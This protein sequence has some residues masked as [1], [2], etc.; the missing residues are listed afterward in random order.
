[1]PQ[2]LVCKAVVVRS[3]SLQL[4]KSPCSSQLE[5]ACVQ[6]RRPSAT[7]TREIIK[8]SIS[9]AYWNYEIKVEYLTVGCTIHHCVII[10]FGYFWVPESLLNQSF[11]CG[12]QSS[13]YFTAPLMQMALKHI[14]SFLNLIGNEWNASYNHN[15]MLFFSS[16]KLN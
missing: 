16:I 12:I 13:V 8:M 15:E 5:E 2:L 9:Q 6:Q 11:E 3:P 7:K 1:M 10:R 14:K 4:E